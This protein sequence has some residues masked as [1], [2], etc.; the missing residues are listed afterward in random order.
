[1]LLLRLVFFLLRYLI[2]RLLLLLF[3]LYQLCFFC[4]RPAAPLLSI[5]LPGAA[6][7]LFWPLFGPSLEP[8]ADHLLAPLAVWASQQRAEDGLRQ[9]VELLW[10]YRLPLLG[11]LWASGQYVL[12]SWLQW[13]LAFLLPAFPYPRRPLP[14]VWRYRPPAHRI[15][16]VD[17]RQ[18]APSLPLRWWDGSHGPLIRQLRPELRLL[19]ATPLA[20]PPP[21][22]ITTQLL[23]AAAS[24]A[25][26]AGQGVQPTALPELA[27]LPLE[28]TAAQPSRAK[29]PR[30]PPPAPKLPP[31]RMGAPAPTP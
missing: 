22:A 3:R 30:R 25:D 19:L 21:N 31:R 11:V 6:L 28:E 8:L 12:M 7:F 2:Y 15:E 13:L 4:A 23:Q 17:C 10:P 24:E 16:H 26:T 9:L 20:L 29:A 1:M 27:P 5:L 18:A 14:P